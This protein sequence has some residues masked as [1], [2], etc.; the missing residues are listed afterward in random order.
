MGIA[1]NA[2]CGPSDG[3]FGKNAPISPR[4]TG[5]LAGGLQPVLRSCK[6]RWRLRPILVGS[7]ATGKLE[8]LCLL[9]YSST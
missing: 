9:P 8:T 7:R 1:R 4:R 6:L 5:Y 3:A 2:D